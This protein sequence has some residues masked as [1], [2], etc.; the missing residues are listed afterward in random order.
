MVARNGAGVHNQSPVI[1]MNAAPGK[2][3]IVRDTTRRYIHPAEIV[4]NAAAENS[5]PRLAAVVGD[6]T[7][8]YIHNAAA[9]INPTAEREATLA[10]RDGA[11]RLVVRNLAVCYIQRSALIE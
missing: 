9:V 7:G 3:S 10:I 6:N 1:V 11:G 4:I 8:S 5:S 2:A